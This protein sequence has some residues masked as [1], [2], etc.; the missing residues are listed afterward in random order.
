MIDYLMEYPLQFT[1]LYKTQVN[2]QFGGLSALFLLQSCE[3]GD[4]FTW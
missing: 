3:Y 1:G 4:R 2:I